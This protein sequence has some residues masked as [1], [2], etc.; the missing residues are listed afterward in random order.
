MLALIRIPLWPAYLKIQSGFLCV[1][2]P[3]DLQT[4]HGSDRN[5]CRLR[6]W[7]PAEA[8]GG[9]LTGWNGFYPPVS[10]LALPGA[11]QCVGCPPAD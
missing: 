8:Q 3:V 2:L 5:E 9:A 11:A 1:N 6:Q 4:A 10:L 7:P